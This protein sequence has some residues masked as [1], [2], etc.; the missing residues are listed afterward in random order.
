MD[1]HSS[2]LQTFINYARKKF[3]NTE[4][5]FH[6]ANR[7]AG[8]A[9]QSASC[10]APQTSELPE[11]S[12]VLPVSCAI[13]QKSRCLYRERYILYVCLC[14]YSITYQYSIPSVYSSVCPSLHLSVRLP[15][16]PI[17]YLSVHPSVLIRQGT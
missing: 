12:S 17:I 14:D 2:L 7:R 9:G 8:I 1:K 16:H 5:R 6:W 15:V 11:D 10:K 13:L 3:Y 4:T